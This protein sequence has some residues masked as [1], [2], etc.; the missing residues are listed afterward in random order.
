MVKKRKLI[1]YGGFAAVM[2]LMLLGIGMCCPSVDLV[3]N[4]EGE[5]LTQSAR[6]KAETYVYSSLA[7]ALSDNV[8]LEITPTSGGVFTTG[9]ATL[10][11]TTNN[12]TGYSVYMSTGDNTSSLHPAN[13]LVDTSIEPVDGSM[14]ASNYTNHLNKWGYALDDNTDYT[15]I[16][17]TNS[18]PI[19]T[20]EE[21]AANEQ[22]KLNFG[23]AVGP[24]LPSGTYYNSVLVSAVANPIAVHTLSGITYMQ[25]M[26]PYVC[27]YSDVG[28]TKQLIDMRDQKAYWVAKLPD[29][30]CWMT[31]NLAL[32]LSTDKTYTSADT[33]LPKGVTYTPTS[34]TNDF[35]FG[36]DNK[37]NS[38][39]EEY[40]WNMGEAV[41]VTPLV[42]KQCS[43]YNTNTV[44]LSAVFGDN[45]G[46]KCASVGI[47]DVSGEDW[48]A[49][50]VSKMGN[51]SY[52]ADTNKV[53]T[54]P[55]ETGATFIAADTASKTYD[56]HYLIGNYYQAS[57]AT[58]GL[59]K[60]VSTVNANSA[61]SICPSGWR[62]PNGE[63][64]SDH[65]PIDTNDYYQL[66][67]GLGYPK[68]TTQ[69]TNPLDDGLVSAKNP[70]APPAYFV[71]TGWLQTASGYLR[72]VGY[73]THFW[74]GTVVD[75]SN[76][77][78]VNA[79]NANLTVT[80]PDVRYVGMPVRCLAR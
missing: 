42:S 75:R 29:N 34:G 45:L 22:Y 38:N 60:N 6:M 7:L 69:Y 50:F 11:I 26:S 37:S 8:A 73:S 67:L 19:I 76:D 65:A 72:D 40:S 63:A 15:A 80:H 28:E 74:S 79:K 5:P 24:T 23:V 59:V 32:D 55:D 68:F 25:E 31:Q 2:C 35:K 56:A 71:H 36:P 51:Y 61:G 16:P 54:E 33:D 44:G 41:V 47:A 57:A 49:D 9:E 17:K 20:S 3:A 18:A 48:T 10:S 14:N 12:T 53:T 1:N 78:A 30:K 70:F 27:D 39:T 52:D 64:E 62:L 43:N 46:I 66:L 4:A 13:G 77:Y 21:M 58:A